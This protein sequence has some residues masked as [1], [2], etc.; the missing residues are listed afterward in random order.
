MRKP[1]F[2][3]ELLVQDYI[4]SDRVSNLS[5]IPK[6]IYLTSKEGIDSE[7]RKQGE[8]EGGRKEEREALI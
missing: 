8:R 3:D 1:R 5:I 2:R 7:G 6:T 4:T